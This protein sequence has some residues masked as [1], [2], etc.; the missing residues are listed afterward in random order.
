MKANWTGLLGLI[1]MYL[2][3]M[4][5]GWTVWGGKDA[6]QGSM[7]PVEQV[8]GWVKDCN[9]KCEARNNSYCSALSLKHD[10]MDQ[11]ECANSGE[12]P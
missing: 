3:G 7:Y 9:F 6:K 5:Q 2:L 10:Q 8:A 11:F 1:V 4:V 12:R